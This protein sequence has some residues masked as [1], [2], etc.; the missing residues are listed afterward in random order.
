MEEPPPIIDPDGNKEYFIDKIL[1][2]CQCGQGYQY[3]VCWSGYGTEHDWWIPG[4]KLQ[5]C[6]ALDCWLALQGTSP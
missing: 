5:D 1:D 4:S 6:E 2:V 3:L